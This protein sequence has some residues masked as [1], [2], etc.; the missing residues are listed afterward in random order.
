MGVDANAAIAD[1]NKAIQLKADYADADY[2][3]GFALGLL[4]TPQDAIA[5][6]QQ[7]ATLYGQQGNSAMKNQALSQIEALKE[8]I[9]KPAPESTNSPSSL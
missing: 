7:A 1:Y 4:G 9:A 3:R 5:S 6:L 8:A 2:N